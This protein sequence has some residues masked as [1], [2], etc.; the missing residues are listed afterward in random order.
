MTATVASHRAG[1][2]VY[3]SYG[4]LSNED[5]FFSYALFTLLFPF[6]RDRM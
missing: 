1:D 3:I 5:L 6:R 4:L 2:Q